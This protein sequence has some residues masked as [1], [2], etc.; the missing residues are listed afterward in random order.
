VES[1]T[2]LNLMYSILTVQH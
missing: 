1:G 2:M